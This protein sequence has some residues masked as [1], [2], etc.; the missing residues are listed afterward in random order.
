MEVID[1][2]LKLFRIYLSSTFIWTLMLNSKLNNVPF[3][4]SILGSDGTT[5]SGSL[6]ALW[7]FF[8]LKRAK[9]VSFRQTLPNERKDGDKPFLSSCQ[10]QKCLGG[11]K[12]DWFIENI[13]G[14]LTEWLNV[15][16]F[17]TSQPL[18]A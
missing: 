1:L 5:K 15:Q 10:S 8:E 13:F 4:T 16:K 6:N 3:L 9:I 17:T 12:V 14:K 11:Y 2:Y 7:V 18:N